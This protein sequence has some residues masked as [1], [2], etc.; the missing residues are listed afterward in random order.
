MHNIPDP[1]PSQD[2]APRALDIRVW[3]FTRDY[4]NIAPDVLFNAIS[5]SMQGVSVFKVWKVDSNERYINLT[6][7][8]IRL[9]PK[10]KYHQVEVDLQVVKGKNPASSVVNFRIIPTLTG[11]VSQYELFTNVGVNDKLANHVADLIFGGIAA[12]F[13]EF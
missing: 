11:I 13:R 12:S 8:S 5:N 10:V 1:P 7:H 3:L 4:P 9:D 6:T 2:D